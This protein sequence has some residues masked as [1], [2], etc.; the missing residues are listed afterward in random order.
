MGGIHIKEFKPLAIPILCLVLIDQIIKIIISS[1]FM[2]LVR[3]DFLGRQFRFYTD[4][5]LY[6]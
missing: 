3:Q 4:N 5:I 2:Q 1:V 6:F